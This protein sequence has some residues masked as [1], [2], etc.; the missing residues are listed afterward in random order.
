MKWRTWGQLIGGLLVV[1]WCL[2]P[3]YW[4]L[5][6]ALATT[7]QI[8]ASQPFFFPHPVTW[9]HF[10]QLLM[11]QGTSGNFWG[12]ALNSVVEAVATTMATVAIATMAGYAFARMRFGGAQGFFLLIVG[13]IAL[14]AYAVIVPLFQMM[15]SMHL[16]GTYLGVVLVEISAVLPLAVWLMRS[17]IAALPASIEDAARIDGASLWVMLSRVVLPLIGPGMASTTIVVFLTS[18]SQF[19]IPLTYAPSSHAEPLTVLITQ[20]VSKHAVDYGLQAA[21]GIM[22][23]IPP[24]ILVLRFNRRVLSGLLTGATTS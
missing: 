13:T 8:N 5:V 1:L 16:V 6:I 19:L 9:A 23:L 4:A 24:A 7:Y 20:F 10:E 18:W 15:S 22:A 3:L 11:G 2:G 17:Y 21:A 12:T 14:P